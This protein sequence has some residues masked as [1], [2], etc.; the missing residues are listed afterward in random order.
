MEGSR[1]SETR[2]MC[3]V[4][5]VRALRFTAYALHHFKLPLFSPIKRAWPRLKPQHPSKRCFSAFGFMMDVLMFAGA[6]LPAGA[7]VGRGHTTVAVK[8][9]RER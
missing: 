1:C 5:N 9:S 3:V 6:G 7:M 8:V 4:D 2:R